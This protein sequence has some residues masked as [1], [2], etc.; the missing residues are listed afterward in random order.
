MGELSLCINAGSSAERDRLQQELA[1]ASSSTMEYSGVVTDV[2][3]QVSRAFGDCTGGPGTQ[4]VGVVTDAA[5]PVYIEVGVRAVL[6][7]GAALPVFRDDV[8]TD[9]Q[10]DLVLHAAEAGA[11]QRGF[12]LLDST[13]V[14]AAAQVGDGPS[15]RLLEA[16]GLELDLGDAYG[17]TAAGDGCGAEQLRELTVDSGSGEAQSLRVGDTRQFRSGEV[18]VDLTLVGA[19]SYVDGTS[20]S[21]VHHNEL[22]WVMT[23]TTE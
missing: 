16:T 13:G 15:D 2:R 14:L 4:W 3:L 11:P 17:A 1:G 10:V 5:D 7:S 12:V 8:P 9:K 22:A 19:R 20:C 18:D 21:D 23:R 6:P